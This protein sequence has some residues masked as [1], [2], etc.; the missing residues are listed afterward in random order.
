[1]LSS[2]TVLI[3]DHR[4]LDV[5]CSDNGEPLLPY[6]L[7]P[8]ILIP[9]QTSLRRRFS[10]SSTPL[11]RLDVIR[12]LQT[13]LKQLPDTL[14]FVIISGYR[15]PRLQR[16]NFET[17]ALDGRYIAD[18]SKF[19]PHCCGGAVDIAITDAVGHLLDF[20][21]L[22]EHDETAHATFTAIS[23]DAQKNRKML[24]IA[25]SSVGFVNYPLEWWHW[26]YGDK[27][28]GYVTDNTAFYDAVEDYYAGA[29]D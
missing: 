1:M 13:A 22:F 7:L 19:A 8:R 12:K 16:R 26:S 29:P 5:Q 10:D 18:P 21:N 27:Y 17:S 2:A 25:L 15:S 9:S 14:S 24:S 20:G 28:W 23:E 6:D 4:I 11:L 3:N